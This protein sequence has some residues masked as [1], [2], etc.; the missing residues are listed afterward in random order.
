MAALRQT[1]ESLTADT[2]HFA[3]WYLLISHGAIKLVLVARGPARSV[4]G[5]PGLHRRDDRI[6]L[7]Q[8][9]R[10]SFEI[11]L[12]LIAITVLDLVVLARA[13]HEYGVVRRERKRSL[14]ANQ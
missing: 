9:Y 10:L 6:I 2:Q 11:S 1:A 5:L 4:V 13:C 12:A 14:D 7:Y 8:D 3:A